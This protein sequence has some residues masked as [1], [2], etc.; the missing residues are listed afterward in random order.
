MSS[1]LVGPSPVT[2]NGRSFWFVLKTELVVSGATDPGA[3]VTVQGVQV[4]LRAD[5]TFSL[6]LPLP[7]GKQ[8][9]D[10]NAVS[11]DGLSERIVAQVITRVTTSS[12][13]EREEH[14]E[15]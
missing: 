1:D 8:V 10:A 6:R 2:G 7:D 13:L 15:G 11:V 5:G 12:E 4:P 3:R 14:G 9:V